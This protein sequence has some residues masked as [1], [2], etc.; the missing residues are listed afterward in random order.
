MPSGEDGIWHGWL[1]ITSQDLTT[2]TLQLERPSPVVEVPKLPRNTSDCVDQTVHRVIASVAELPLDVRLL[3]LGDDA[4]SHEI[5]EQL[6]RGYQNLIH[7]KTESRQVAIQSICVE[8]P[9]D[10]VRQLVAPSVLGIVSTNHH[11]LPLFTLNKLSVLTH[12]SM[13]A[14]A[15]D[16][17]KLS[18]L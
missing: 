14:F 7:H 8:A 13:D 15:R 16:R 9:R 6:I 12:N 3:I 5:A 10:Y 4:S 17:L 2:K 1:V 18:A 11:R